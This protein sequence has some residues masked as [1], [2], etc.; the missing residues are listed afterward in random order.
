MRRLSLIVNPRAARGRTIRALPG[1]QVELAR[2]G[3]PHRCAMTRSLEHAGALARSA[4]AGGEVAVAFGGDG[5]VG[6][7]AAAVS[8][9]DGVLG[10]LPGGRGNDF[11]RTLGIPLDPR[12][13]CDVL[14]T[15][16][17]APL[18]LGRA[19]ART[20]IGIASC[21]F[22]SDANRIANQARHVPGSLVY[23]YGALRALIGWKPARFTVTLDDEAPRTVAGY[24]VAAANSRAYGSGMFLAPDASLDDGRLDVVIIRDVTKLR[25]LRLLPTVFSGRHV[26]L[27]NVEILRA[28]EVTVSAERPVTMY[29]DGD[30][31]G[32][33][34]LTLTVTRAA[35]RTIVPR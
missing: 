1:V 29:A 26:R 17:I 3:L 32:E 12:K 2:R 25:F 19:G 9:S 18:D 13:A 4:A 28:R 15:G 21:G 16:T 35:F 31:L 27:R 14:A 34:P 30:P 33:L 11:A 22:D 20:F 6:A 8:Q 7:V 10:V 24:S 23:V 5:L